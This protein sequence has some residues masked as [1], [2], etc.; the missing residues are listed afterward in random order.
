MNSFKPDS[1]YCCGGLSLACQYWIFYQLPT[2][3]SRSR[4]HENLVSPERS[5]CD[6]KGCHPH[7]ERDPI[8]PPKGVA[9]QVRDEPLS[10]EL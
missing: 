10:L 9:H 3:P 7:L 5:R 1:P 2:I 6:V 4:S 8:F